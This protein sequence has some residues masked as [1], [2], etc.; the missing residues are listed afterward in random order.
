MVGYGGEGRVRAVRSAYGESEYGIS[1]AHLPQSM[2]VAQTA[3][4]AAGQSD[5]AWQVAQGCA[6]PQQGKRSQR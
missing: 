4:S 5:A 3:W 6:R 1:L 2:R